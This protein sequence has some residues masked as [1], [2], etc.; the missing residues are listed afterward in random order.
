ERRIGISGDGNV[1]EM[2]I[3]EDKNVKEEFWGVESGD[4]GEIKWKFQEVGVLKMGI[5][6]SG[7]FEKVRILEK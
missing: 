4:F 2:G 1:G 3:W 6:E 7:N 5:L